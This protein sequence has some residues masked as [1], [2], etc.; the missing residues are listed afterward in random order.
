M[1]KKKRKS[2]K[3]EEPLYEVF[4]VKVDSY[5]VAS[6]AGTSDVYAPQ[7]AVNLDLDDP[8]YEHR[9]R[10]TL[11]GTGLYPPN[12]KGH[13]FEISLN[14][15]DAPSSD[16]DIKLKDCKSATRMGRQNIGTTENSICLCFGTL[17]ELPVSIS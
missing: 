11:L 14:G 9:T 8:L 12:Y 3:A 13:R 7:Y 4:S 17:K 10:I 16:M 1:A 2:G 15:E 5:D 6:E